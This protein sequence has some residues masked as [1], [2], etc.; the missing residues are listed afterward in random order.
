MKA[1]D[2]PRR[3]AT[4]EH[5]DATNTHTRSWSWFGRQAKGQR[6]ILTFSRLLWNIKYPHHEANIFHISQEHFLNTAMFQT[7]QNNAAN[8]Q[9][10]HGKMAKS[11]IYVMNFTKIL[12]LSFVTSFCHLQGGR[13]IIAFICFL[14][15]CMSVY[16]SVFTMSLY[17][18]ETE[19]FTR[20]SSWNTCGM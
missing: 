3:L 11:N 7:G 8:W 14:P 6:E 17:L 20:H 10:L 9:S 18:R 19:T 16:H 15:V 1:D 4:F 12:C 2:E 13:S 5:N